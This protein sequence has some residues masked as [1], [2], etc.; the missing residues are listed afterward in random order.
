MSNERGDASSFITSRANTM[1]ETDKLTIRSLIQIVRA[2][3]RDY[4]NLNRLVN[5]RE[6]S[7]RQIAAAMYLAVNDWNA[8]PPLIDPITL[9]SHP[10]KVLLVDGT[11]I[12]LYW[13]LA[14]LQTRNHM[15]YSDAQGTRV[16]VSDKAPQLMQLMGQLQGRYDQQKFQLKQAIN[17]NG[18][19]DGI[20]I[21]SEYGAV[22]GALDWL[23]DTF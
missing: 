4:E 1:T 22:N 12:Q 21:D 15:N 16:G 2:K 9:T 23:D 5:G 13:S 18:A 10:S 19:L 11:I 3:L 8:A 17:L 6:N 7:N 14:A 20:G